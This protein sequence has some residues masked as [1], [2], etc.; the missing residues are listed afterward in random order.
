MQLRKKII[1]IFS[2]ASCAVS[3]CAGAVTVSAEIR[4]GKMQYGDYL[5]YIQ[6]DEDENGIFDYIEIL[7]CDESAKEIMI[8]AEI[9]GL[10]VT[11]ISSWGFENCAG[12][13]SIDIPDS[14]EIINE[15]A[16][17]GCYSLEN[18][19]VSPDNKSY[20]SINGILFNKTTL[21]K[22]PRNKKDIDYS[23]P[24]G[25]ASIGSG[26]FENC[27]SLVSIEIPDSVTSIG[28]NA[29]FNCISLT[30]INIPDSVISIEE[31]AFNSCTSL[32]DITIGKS[33]AS[34]GENAFYD[35]SSLTSMDI[36]GSVTS[37][38][39]L[40]CISLKSINVA[41]D[42]KNYS[43]VDGVLFNK[44]KTILMEYPARKTDAE[45]TIPDSVKQI[46]KK[47]FYCCTNLTSVKIGKNAASIGNHAFCHCNHLVNI[48][49]PD[50]ITSIGQST[51]WNC[52]SLES[53]EIPD[54]V[55][56]IGATAFYGC[57]SLTS[58][59]ILNPDCD[60]FD[61]DSTIN[62]G[63]DDNKDY[64]FNGTIY[65]YENS[66]ALQYANKYGFKL[67]SL[68]EKPITHIKGDANNDGTL[69]I[70]DAAFIAI[71]CAKGQ[72][73]DIPQWADYND[74][75][76]RNIRDAAAIAIYCA[77]RSADLVS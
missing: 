60:I 25:I 21:I 19:N 70:R 69:N 75:G 57:A 9:D 5:T 31:M 46:G 22:Y 4:S 28:D 3:L 40:G 63:Y 41:A 72:Y 10:P 44:D 68:G 27:K 43:S 24:V 53:I 76:K 7:E 45:Y 62:N 51:F 26:A 56:S 35:C 11:L 18:I 77:K 66:T 55:T 33:V 38:G 1:S 52:A 64:Y 54:S 67:E 58:I 74:D 17:S 37:I 2:A 49:L 30:N 42:N 36:P 34:I 71:A 23:I 15:S 73:D 16:F 13:V 32:A 8:P 14:I 39:N 29:F 50:G 20:S 47:A 48:E 6:I 12:L 61:S 65:G 59:S